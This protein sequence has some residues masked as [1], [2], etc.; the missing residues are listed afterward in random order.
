MKLAV[1]PID[2][3]YNQEMLD[4]LLDSPM[5]SDGLT[6]CLDRTPDIFAIPTLFFNQYRAYGFFIDDHLKGFA[7]IC[8]KSLYINGK[9]REIGYLANMYVLPEARKR[10]WL[11][12]ASEPLFREV[13]EQVGFGFATTVKGNLHTE[14]MI[15]R[16]IEKFPL[17]PHSRMIRDLVIKNILITFRK[18]SHATYSTRRA[19]EQ[20]I[21]A[22]SLLLDEEYKTRLFGPVSDEKELRKTIAAR[23][24]FSVSDY[25]VAEKDDRIVGVCSAWDISMIRNIRVMAYRKKF[26]WFKIFYSVAAPFFGFPALPKP[27]EAFREVTLNDYA[28]EERDPAILEAL[29]RRIYIDCRKKGYN[30]IQIAS[31]QGD[32]LL[33][34]TR[35]FLS[36]PLGSRIIIGSSDPDFVEKEGID[37]SRPYIDI[38]LT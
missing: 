17:I 13:L 28:V 16:R 37:C 12:K 2:Q 3:E 25:Y 24:G 31:F 19:T 22:I 11:Y 26:R 34:A 32:P 38:A 36:Q 21:P 18:R 27:G 35:N 1:L 10:G 8:R 6:L 7:M 29:L 4:I 5:E 30:M 14:P 33:K 20:D 23:P 15:G 9:P